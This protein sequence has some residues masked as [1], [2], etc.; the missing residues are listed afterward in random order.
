MASGS[1]W[2]KL[3]GSINSKLLETLVMAFKTSVELVVFG[4]TMYIY[5]YLHIFIYLGRKAKV[6]IM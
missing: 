5:I 6:I 1:R 2:K 4:F 3:Q